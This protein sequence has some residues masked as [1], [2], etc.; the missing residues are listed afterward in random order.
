[1]NDNY[2]LNQEDN[3][4][5]EAWDAIASQYA[6]WLKGG[7]DVVGKAFTE[8]VTNNMLNA[9]GDVKGKNVLDLGCGEGYFT[10]LLAGRGAQLK[11]IDGSTK[12]I[13]L[14]KSASG[15]EIS[16]GV[17]DITSNLPYETN[18][19]DLV[20]CH[21]VLMDIENINPIFKEVARVLKAKGEF[22]FSIVHPCYYQAIGDWFDIE[23][24]RPAFR[25]KAR[26]TEQVRYM[27]LI[28]GLPSETKLPHYNRP[29]QDYLK[30]IIANSLYLTNFIETSFSKEV[31]E[32]KEMFAQ[33]KQF[34]LGANNL[35]VA[36]S[37]P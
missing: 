15:E 33:F 8:I 23:T 35:I 16:F 21:M 7:I 5:I 2:S 36:A 9:I 26:Y 13:E 12:M 28:D 25:F 37:K 1:M 14:A 10:R 18:S 31:L 6:I 30:P 29:I 22:F 27:K 34:Y 24:D 20:V 11:A 3:N 32:E 19:F 17:G 4:D